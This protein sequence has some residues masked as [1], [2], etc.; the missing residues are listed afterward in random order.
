VKRI[1]CRQP[2]PNIGGAPIYPAGYGWSLATTYL[3]WMA[4]VIVMYPICRWLANLKASRREWWLS[5]V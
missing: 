4:V 5:Y 3:V 2:S 1:L